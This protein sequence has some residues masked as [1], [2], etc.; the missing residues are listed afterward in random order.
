MRRRLLILLASICALASTAAESPD[1]LRP[2][3]PVVSAYTLAIGSAH[4]CNTYLTPLHYT[5]LTGRLHYERM[6]AMA[7]NP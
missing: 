4:I 3:R 6:Q 7:F 5:G 2:Y 1:S